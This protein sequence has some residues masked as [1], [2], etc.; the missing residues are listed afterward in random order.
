MK[1][2]TIDAFAAAQLKA[3]GIEHDTLEDRVLAYILECAKKRKQP[4]VT[5]EIA[6][7]LHAKRTT[8]NGALLRLLEARKIVKIAQGRYIPVVVNRSE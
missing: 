7:A 8:V 3:L 1:N 6:T 2:S 4:A 5:G